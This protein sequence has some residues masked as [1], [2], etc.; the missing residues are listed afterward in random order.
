MFK[1]YVLSYITLFLSNICLIAYRMKGSYVNKNGILVETFFLVP[2]GYL[3]FFISMILFFIV[4]FRKIKV[5]L[6][7][8]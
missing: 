1:N 2:L 6:K 7:N 3:F 8:K 5:K 4:T